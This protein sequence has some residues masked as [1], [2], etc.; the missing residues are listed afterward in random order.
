M[1]LYF[2]PII[3]R[4]CNQK[5]QKLKVAVIATINCTTVALWLQI[6]AVYPKIIG[7]SGFDWHKLSDFLILYKNKVSGVLDGVETKPLLFH[8][9]ET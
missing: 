9:F 3:C 1:H 6:F 5:L 4:D 2:A 8:Y 7:P